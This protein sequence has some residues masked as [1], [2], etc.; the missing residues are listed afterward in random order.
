MTYQI[1][2]T[3]WKTHQTQLSLIR[4]IVFIEEQNVPEELEWDEFDKDCIHILV[5]GQHNQAIAC[6]RMKLDGHIGRM[7]VLKKHRLT[8]IGSAMLKA[9]LKIAGEKQYSKVY[10]H[11][12]TSAIAFYENAGFNVC[13]DEF[14]DANI[15]HR[16]MEKHL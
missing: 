4:K 16:T 1:H 10:L 5:T 14:M 13:S 9:L 3:D 8:G 11:A 12:Q 15:P 6:S 2:I 7:A